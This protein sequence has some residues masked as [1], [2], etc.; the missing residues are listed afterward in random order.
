MKILING[1]YP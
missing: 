1:G